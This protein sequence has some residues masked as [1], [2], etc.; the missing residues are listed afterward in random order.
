MWRDSTLGEIAERDAGLIQ[1]GPFG[2][3]LHQSDYRQDG[4]PV[5]MPRDIAEGRVS[6]DS[7]ARVSEE[8]ADRL[9]RHKLK[10]RTIVVPRRGEVTKRAF[11]RPEQEGWICGTGC[12]KIELG[13]NELLPEYLYYFMQQGHVVQWLEQH[14]VGT[15]MRNLSAGIVSGLPI[16]YPVARVQSAIASML[17]AYDDLIENNRRRM[18]LLEQA[19]RLL[20]DE[21]FVRHRFPG[22]H[23][24]RFIDDL[25]EGWARKTLAD[26]GEI[27]RAS[28][29]SN[30]DGEIEYVD[31]ASVTPGQIT[32]TTS[33]T[34]R[35]APSRARRIVQHGDVIWS[36]VRP[37]RRSHALVWGPPENLIVSTGFAVI[38]PVL[39]PSSFLYL[40]TTT[41]AF[42]GYLENHARGVAYPAVVAQDFE[43]AQLVVP[44]EGLLSAFDDAVEPLLSQT[45]NLRQQNR[46]LQAARNLLLPRLMSGEI[47][48]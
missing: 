25:P 8:T 48:V 7:V 11:I 39:V 46:K 36:C 33:Y 32:E 4:V 20:Y 21:W 19:A 43:R 24:T 10:P 15:T 6:D 23:Y 1:T 45:H 22:H 26:V 47:A 34:L 28:L 30:F 31:I 2:S 12:L 44:S 3:Q 16:R 5:I 38:T 18:A 14:A 17:S 40:A 9:Q 37:N 35:D 13:G 27:N 29:S 42:V 41:D